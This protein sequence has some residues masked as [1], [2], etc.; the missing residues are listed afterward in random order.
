MET[1]PIIKELHD[2]KIRTLMVTGDNV[3]TA[4]S[5]SRKCGMVLPNENIA[6]LELDSINIDN[7]DCYEAPKL[8]LRILGDDSY[9]MYREDCIVNLNNFEF[10]HIALDGMT[11]SAL[12]TYYPEFVSNIIL[13][14][15]IFAR[16]RP[17]QKT[18]LVTSLQ[19]LDYIVAMCGD[20]AND[21]GALKAA[22]IGVSLSQA[23]ASVA[24]PFTSAIENI[25]CVKHLML[26]GRCALVTSFSLFKYMAMYSLIQFCT[27][28]IL[29]KVRY[30]IV[31]IKK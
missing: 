28:L 27:V 31:A 24:A 3:M 15:T 26:E 17:E 13:S 19:E 25:S 10:D 6:L 12:R 21:C 5:V 1:T 14:G 29:Y 16:F 20:G 18:Q 23:E 7:S 9:G 2:A 11:W 4:I 8:T 22:H 30:T